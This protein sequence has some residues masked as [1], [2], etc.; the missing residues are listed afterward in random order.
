MSSQTV[1]FNNPADITT[2]QGQVGSVSG[3]VN[4]QVANITSLF[5]TG[6][7]SNLSVNRFVDKYTINNGLGPYKVDAVPICFRENIAMPKFSNNL[8]IS[9]GGSTNPTGVGG[10][11]YTSTLYDT[12]LGHD[13]VVY[14]P[15][16]RTT[17]ET[18]SVFKETVQGECDN[19]GSFGCTLADFNGP[20][21]A[22]YNTSD[23][24]TATF[25]S[26]SLGPLFNTFYALARDAT[27]TTGA[28]QAAL[29]AIYANADYAT[30][31]NRFKYPFKTFNQIKSGSDFQFEQLYSLSGA[32][33]INTGS[34]GVTGYPTQITSTTYSATGNLLPVESNVNAISN[35]MGLFIFHMGDGN[36]MW[37]DTVAHQIASWGYAVAFIPGTPMNN[38]INKFGLTKNIA[39]MIADKDI[40]LVSATGSL[41]G[42]FFTGGAANIWAAY[43]STNDNV[44]ANAGVNGFWRNAF[45]QMLGTAPAQEIMERYYYEIRCVLQKLGVGRYINYNNV[46]VGGISGG[47]Y[48]VVS[49]SK[50][51]SNG[52][53]TQYRINGGSVPLF[54]TKAFIELQAVFPEYSQKVD[55]GASNNNNIYNNRYALGINV[56]PCPFI[57][58]TTDADS[59]N[60]AQIAAPLADNRFNHQLQT[61]FQCTKQSAMGSSATATSSIRNLARSAV[62][63]KSGSSHTDSIQLSPLRPGDGQY[64][65]SIYNESYFTEWMNGWYLNTVPQWPA[66]DSTYE[67]GLQNE[68]AYTMMN[69]IKANTIVELMAH[70]FLGNDYPVPQSAMQFMGLKCDIGPT[71]CEVIPEMEYLRVG[72]LAQ[73]SY[74]DNYNIVLKNNPNVSTAT[75]SFNVIAT[76]SN[77]IFK[78]ITASTGSFTT[79]ISVPTIQATTLNTTTVNATT[80]A[81][82]TAFTLPV[83]DIAGKPV[84]GVVGQVIVISDSPTVAGKLAFWDTTNSRWSYVFDNSAV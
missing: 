9:T 66:I 37:I 71:H 82:T 4:T 79:S 49:V 34:D 53:S 72:P 16:A 81:F 61:V 50:F 7:I 6:A 2:L 64:G 22:I 70:R 46:V 10:L 73:M 42:Y 38:R 62:F 32:A 20:I 58:I 57:A 63:Y 84:S 68:I 76:G 74:D 29:D 77:G 35:Q 47:G 54:T 19:L 44:V 3:Q 41:A 17:M 15:S 67:S 45:R 75:Q 12:F 33:L 31:K 59:G 21:S 56:L 26:S 39:K 1:Y 18:S 48:G 14:L 11:H 83:Y 65:A 40:P 55:A 36:N 28:R 60:T 78:G 27:S 43:D 30:V 52:L 13:I 5:T 23:Q 51:I 25:G 69:D 24:W 80:G 8:S